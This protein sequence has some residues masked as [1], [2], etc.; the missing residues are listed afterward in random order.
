MSHHSLIYLEDAPS[1]ATAFDEL[2]IALRTSPEWE[3]VDR[4]VDIRLVPEE[5]ESSH[6]SVR[7][8]LLSAHAQCR[9]VECRI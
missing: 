6:R 8:F 3:Y 5:V 9:L 1:E 4:E 7:C 2:L